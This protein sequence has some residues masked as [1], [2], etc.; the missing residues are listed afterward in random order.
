MCT[1]TCVC[2]CMYIYVPES[3]LEEDALSLDGGEAFHQIE[4]QAGDILGRDASAQQR[5]GTHRCSVLIGQM[6]ERERQRSAVKLLRL[7]GPR[8][9]R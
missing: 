7:L 3:I 9:S 6:N 5:A 4:N 8:E 1:C 2:A